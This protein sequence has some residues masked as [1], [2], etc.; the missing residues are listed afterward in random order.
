MTIAASV[1][2]GV[3]STRF[4]VLECLPAHS[5][6]APAAHCGERSRAVSD[7][8]SCL[9]RPPLVLHAYYGRWR[10]RKR[11]VGAA[12][13]SCPG[14][15][16]LRQIYRERLQP[17]VSGRH[18]T[19]QPKRADACSGNRTR[20]DRPRT[21]YCESAYL[22]AMLTAALASACCSYPQ[23]QHSKWTPERYVSDAPHFEQS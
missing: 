18:H 8:G 3:H 21:G 6:L 1:A 2:T 23:S 4:S 12:R 13:R 7:T 22:V 14:M 5:Q 16:R 15:G 11:R 20:A 10:L 19:R 9:A 17:T